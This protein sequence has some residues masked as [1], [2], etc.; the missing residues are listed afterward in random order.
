[1]E[2]FQERPIV[3]NVLS[4]ELLTELEFRYQM[5]R[6]ASE[7]LQAHQTF[8]FLVRFN[9]LQ[10]DSFYILRSFPSIALRI[11]TAFN[12]VKCSCLGNNGFLRPD[13]K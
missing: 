6:C 11:P 4:R 9:S 13:A 3:I 1:M 12:F 8:V 10:F 5:H 7:C 2:F